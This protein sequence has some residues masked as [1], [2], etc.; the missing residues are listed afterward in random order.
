M[1]RKI[2][3]LVKE[4]IFGLQRVSG[5]EKR[6]ILLGELRAEQIRSKRKIANLADAEFSVFSQWGEDGILS[7]LVDTIEGKDNCFVEFGVEDFREANC[8]YLLMSRNWSGLIIDGGQ[9]NVDAIKKDAI[10][11]K[12][13]LQS[14]CSFITKENIVSLLTNA[15][16]SSKLG[17]LSVDIDGVDYWVL[18]Q[19]KNPCD[20]IV[21]EYNAVFGDA[22]VSVP[23]DPA[24]VRLE[25]HWSGT[26]WGASLAAFR[27]LLEPRGYTYVGTNS[28]GTNAFFVAN[29]HAA[30]TMARMDQVKTWPCKMRE[31]RLESGALAYKTYSEMR[32]E[33]NHLPVVNVKTGNVQTV[34]EALKVETQ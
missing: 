18:E 10:S 12:H 4:F 2:K 27:F 22:L 33:I 20:I 5:G 29:E 24:F 34:L 28:V 3:N 23:Y 7:W 14:V 15:G 16:Y 25:K 31:A 11:Y 21:V 8:R 19:I 13:D 30:E 32:G 6:S 17:V 9:S 1:K 26:Y